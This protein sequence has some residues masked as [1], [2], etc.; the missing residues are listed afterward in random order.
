MPNAQQIGLVLNYSWKAMRRTFEPES[1]WWKGRE[2]QAREWD[3]GIG[4]PEALVK[5]Y[6][7]ADMENAAM[8]VRL[9][10]AVAVAI[11]M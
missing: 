2:K 10:L 11:N 9:S 4:S 7:T 6:K 5:R 8:K 3:G 1:W